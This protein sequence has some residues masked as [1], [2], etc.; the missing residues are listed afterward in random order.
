MKNKYLIF[1]VTIFF[2]LVSINLK[3]YSQIEFNFDITEIEI[4][5]NGNKYIGYKRGFV[6]TNE[7]IT[8]E[9]DKFQYEKNLN[10]LEAYGNVEINDKINNYVI[11]SNQIT[12]DKNKEIILTSNNSKAISKNDGFIIQAHKFNYNI[13]LNKLIAEKN[14]IIEDKKEDYKI[15]SDK[16]TYLKNEE[17]IFTE[18]TTEGSIYSKYIFKSKDIVFFKNNLELISKNKTTIQDDNSNFY[19]LDKFSY[20]LKNEEVKGQNILIISNYNLPKS[21]KVFFTSGIID[22]K[23]QNFIAQNIKI[24]THKTIFNNPENQPRLKGVSSRKDGHITV[25]NKGIF[26]SCKEND[27]CPP[28]VIEANE[29]KHDKK[30][31]QLIYKDAL[32]KIYDFPVF[33]FPKFFHPD[34]SVERQSGFLK[35]SLNNSNTLG[36]SITLPYFN[37]I[38]N[39]QDFTFTPIWFDSET[40]MANNEYRKVNKNSNLII[41]LGFVNGYKSNTSNKKK[42]I[43]HLFIDYDRD[44]KLNNFNSSKLKLS[45]EKISS[46]T[47]LKVFDTHLTNSS[48]SPENLNTL[49]THLKIFLDNENYNF[50]SGF[51]IYENLKSTNKDKY[52]YVF[53]YYNFDRV[54]SEDFFKGLIILN[55]SGSNN[56]IDTNNL[57]SN[58]IN[59]L[60]YN[61]TDFI[62]DLGFK[63]NFNIYLKNLNS[64][65]KK[66][67]DYKTS[68]QIELT[69]LFQN[70]LSFPLIKNNNDFVS[71]LTPKA[72]LRINPTDM[73]NYSTSDKKIDIGNIFSTNRLGIDDSFEAG[74]SLTLGL[75]YSREKRDLEEVNKYFELK[76]GT[77]IRD[78]EQNFIPKKSTINRKNSN[79]FGSIENKFSKNLSINYD[80]ALD[81]NLK[82]FEYNDLN[83]T[84]SLNNFVTKFNFIEEAGEMGNSN[85]LEGNVS[86]IVDENNSI[87]FNTRRNRKLNLTEYYN[88][89]YQYKNDC[90]TAGIKYKKS[91][92]E[93][94]DL[95]PSEDLLFTVTLYPLTSFDQ[96]VGGLIGN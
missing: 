43:N 17:K 92:Y 82:N 25:I 60:S 90:L 70:D 77:V 30:K 44:L 49:N 75:D 12:Y 33:Y 46:D 16:I 6:S 13:P 31:K 50:E 56:L 59:D 8:I 95:K 64:I 58:I 3:A 61:G 55:S 57:K 83:A 81:N 18:G 89:V 67:P 63:S 35:P 34:P 2:T 7:G 78:K 52:Q 32:L 29:I 23:N 4:T 21:D 40:L 94:R 53:P 26:T 11:Y 93:D 41:D 19:S 36:S 74:R 45:I 38:S 85:V 87:T 47:Y 86:Y 24:E 27:K 73:K 15:I 54:L 71:L 69:A 1:F 66:N 10:T 68:P 5:E 80:F 91:Y 42:N 9:A 51:E 62:A 48:A 65:G 96:D 84:L 14:V 72:S 76:L 79:L 37:V 88:L 20:S 28:W 22:L 39:N